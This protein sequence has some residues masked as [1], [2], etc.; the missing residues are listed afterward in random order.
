M[1]TTSCTERRTADVDIPR[2]PVDD[3]RSQHRDAVST[4][5]SEGCELLKG[6][7]WLASATILNFPSA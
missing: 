6:L 7:E 1:C 5:V 3:E 4:V 2:P